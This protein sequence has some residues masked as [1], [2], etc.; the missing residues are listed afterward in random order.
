MTTLRVI[1]DQMIAPVPG[2]IGRYTEELTRALIATAPVDC[3]VEGIVSASSPEQCARIEA[4]LPGL[5]GLHR[6][7][8]GRRELAAAWQLGVTIS[9]GP[10]MIHAPGLLAPL[11]RHNRNND[12]TQVAVT[13]HDALAWTHP[14]ALTPATVAWTKAMMK[15]AK[16]YA[17][18]IVVPSHAVA[19]QLAEIVDLGD[20]V[21]VIGSAVGSG[22]RLPSNSSATEVVATNL[23]LPPEF[24]VTVGSLEPRRGITALVTALGMPAAPDLP[25]IVVGPDSWGELDLA[26]VADEAGLE[27]GR[28]RSMI[29]LT[30]EELAVVISRASALVYPTLE[31]GFALPIIQAF[32]LGTPVVHSDAAALLEAAGDAGLT[33]ERLDAAGYPERLAEAIS[34]VLGDSALSARL[35]IA[36]GDRAR[37]FTWR[38]SAERV[39]QLHADL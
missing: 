12:D 5:S 27:P 4:A 33:V 30:D 2:G 32:H 24:L 22:L 38:D 1:V 31:E 25:L 13:V 3:D 23:A 16:R 17:D 28:V 9:P 26:S 19:G 39:W 14:E 7:A 35:R 21:R 34:R 8:L 10:G 36:G 11:R 37:A 20:R 29:G 18:A 6:T 15:R